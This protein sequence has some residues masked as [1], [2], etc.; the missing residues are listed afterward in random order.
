MP[1]HYHAEWYQK[2]QTEERNLLQLRMYD[3]EVE[4]TSLKWRGHIKDLMKKCYLTVP[5]I[6]RRRRRK[7]RETLI[8]TTATYLISHKRPLLKIQKHFPWKILKMINK[9]EY[10][11]SNAVLFGRWLPTFRG[12]DLQDKIYLSASTLQI[13]QNSTAYNT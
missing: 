7:K 11:F 8:Q 4:S 13:E 10:T 9:K 3:T 2:V 1:P 6:C 5:S 12:S